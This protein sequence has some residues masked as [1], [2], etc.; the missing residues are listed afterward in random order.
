MIGFRSVRNASML[1]TTY[2]VSGLF[3]QLL[4]KSLFSEIMRPAG[5]FGT[6]HP[7]H[8]VDGVTNFMHQS[9]P[10]G[11]STSAFAFFFGLCL[12][13]DRWSVKLLCFIGAALVAYSRVYLS[14]H[15][16]QDIA[17]GAWIGTLFA[18]AGYA[19]FVHNRTAKINKPLIALLKRS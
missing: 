11:H 16:L 8:L 4:K 15:F 18:W 5:Y 17:V 13:S 6:S 3:V 12:L 10:S 9:F 7:L 1:L 2:I 19:V 14:Q